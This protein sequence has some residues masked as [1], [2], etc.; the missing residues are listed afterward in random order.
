MSVQENYSPRSGLP[1][2][3]AGHGAGRPLRP[4]VEGAVLGAPVDVAPLL[5]LLGAAAETASPVGNTG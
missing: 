5:L 2:R 1:P 4:E 3:A